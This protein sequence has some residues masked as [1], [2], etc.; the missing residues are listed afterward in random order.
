MGLAVGLLGPYEDAYYLDGLLFFVS[1][2]E[3]S[4]GTNPSPEDSFPLLRI[5]CHL[6]QSTC[7]TFLDLAW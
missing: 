5:G 2:K 4:I 6:I 7:D 3:N 1:Q